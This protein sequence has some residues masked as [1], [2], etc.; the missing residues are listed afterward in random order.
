NPPSSSIA[1]IAHAERTLGDRLVEAGVLTDAQLADALEVHQTLAALGEPRWL[2][3]LVVTLGFV[4]AEHLLPYTPREYRGA[5]LH[6][7]EPGC[8]GALATRLADWLRRFSRLV[9]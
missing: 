4:S 8:D 5:W 7:E 9:P 1:R 6:R 3:E 2:G